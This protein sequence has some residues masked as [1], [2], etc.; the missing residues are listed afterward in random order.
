MCWE[1]TIV[2]VST[3][4]II[5]FREILPIISDPTQKE[6]ILIIL[7]IL[8]GLGVVQLTVAMFSVSRS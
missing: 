8:A 4:G 6:K 1:T 3:A 7:L 5:A 2:L